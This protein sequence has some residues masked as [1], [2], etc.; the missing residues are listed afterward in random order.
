MLMRLSVR[1]GAPRRTVVAFGVGLV[2]L[3]VAMTIGLVLLTGVLS[4]FSN[5]LQSNRFA[6][7]N[8]RLNQ[9]LN[10]A[11]EVMVRDVRRAGYWGLAEDGI[12]NAAAYAANPFV[13]DIIVGDGGINT[14]TTGCVLFRY[15][16]SD[17]GSLQ[18]SERVGYKLSSGAV[19]MLTAATSAAH[20]C[21]SGTWESITD[22]KLS[23]VT[24]LT[25]GKTHVSASPSSGIVCTRD[26]TITLTGQLVS[27]STV[28]QTLTQLV[29]V[30]ADWYGSSS[31]CPANTP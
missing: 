10:G 2:E 25:F 30:R 1:N 29:R 16:R 22:S 9:E 8:S 7:Q 15:D 11:M 6:T 3:L 27:D 31:T 5:S 14:T 24:A 21:A 23:T 19:Q 13:A 4:I 18:D 12:G 17:D 20:S 26:I 28:T